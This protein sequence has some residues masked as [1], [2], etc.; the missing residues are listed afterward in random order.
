MFGE[1]EDVLSSLPERRKPERH[2]GQ[3]VEEILAE[4]SPARARVQILARGGDDPDVNRLGT[5]TAQPSNRS[6]L[7]D[8]Q[9]LRLQRLGQQPDFVEEECAPVG[10]LEQAGF[11]MARIG[12]RALLE[13]EELRLEER[14]WN[15]RAVDRDERPGRPR[16][17]FV[18]GPRQQAL[19][20]PC[21]P[22]KQNGRKP[23][24]RRVA[25]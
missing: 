9:Q 17:G 5:R 25:P 16:T 14:F 7:E 4:P 10:R 2:D 19:A 22:E 8:R 3:P 11:R 18:E 23:A 6:V 24:C 20:C 13:A 21:L 12:E 1:G 15:G